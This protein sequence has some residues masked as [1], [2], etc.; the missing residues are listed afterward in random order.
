MCTVATLSEAP[1]RWLIGM[2][3]G[4]QKPPHELTS[5]ATQHLKLAT[6]YGRDD[7]AMMWSLPQKVGVVGGSQEQVYS[8]RNPPSL[9]EWVFQVQV[10]R[11]FFSHL[12]RSFQ[13]QVS[14][15]QVVLEHWLQPPIHARV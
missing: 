7:N 6:M 2:L 4:G 8:F 13:V 14:R 1:V 5:M 3:L 15:G 12:A 11:E 9:A 10:G